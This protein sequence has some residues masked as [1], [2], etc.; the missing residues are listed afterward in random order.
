MQLEN[1]GHR[2]LKFFKQFKLCRFYILPRDIQSTLWSR[3][4]V[5][6]EEVVMLLKHYK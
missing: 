1:V 6:Q 5:M 2:S 4:R 3:T